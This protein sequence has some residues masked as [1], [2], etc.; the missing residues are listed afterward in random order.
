MK[1]DP[2]REALKT[3]ADPHMICATCPWDRTCIRPPAMT[4]GDVEEALNPDTIRGEAGEGEGSLL[5][6]MIKAMTFAGRD[7]AAPVC[8]VLV[9]RLRSSDGKR[10]A[11]AL[12]ELMTSWVD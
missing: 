4:T 5:V 1:S 6:A 11:D 8:P 12:R 2:I 9:D 7:T 3:G 10:I